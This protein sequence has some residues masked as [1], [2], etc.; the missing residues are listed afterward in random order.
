MPQPR[1]EHNGNHG[2]NEEGV[3]FLH[4]LF[5]ILE[6]SFHKEPAYNKSGNPKKIVI[7]YLNKAQFEEGAFGVPVKA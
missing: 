4:G 5:L 6:D 7:F 2:V 1:T 3:Q